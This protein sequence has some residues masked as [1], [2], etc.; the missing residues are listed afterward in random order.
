MALGKIKADTLEH[1]TAGT[2]DTQFVVDGSAKARGQHAAGTLQSG[3]LNHSSITDH[4]TG[5]FSHNF[6][7]SF[8]N[9]LYSHVGSA[10]YNQGSSSALWTYMRE[11]GSAGDTATGSIKVTSAYIL[12]SQNRTDYDFAF[13]DLI[14]FGDLA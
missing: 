8:A 12:S 3:S 4:A 13:V 2:V 9:I 11:D 6:T 14:C 10:T 7:N 1:S 5:S